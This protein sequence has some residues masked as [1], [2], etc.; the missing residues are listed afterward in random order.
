MQESYLQLSF[1][2]YIY[3]VAH[4]FTELFLIESDGK[5]NNTAAQIK[6]MTNEIIKLRV[7]V[8]FKPPP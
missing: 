8:M 3:G 1:S 2:S 7:D 5:N 6:I 4:F